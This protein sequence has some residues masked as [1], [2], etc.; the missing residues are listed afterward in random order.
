MRAL[1][2]DPGTK[3]FDICCIEDDAV[4]VVLDESI[5]TDIVAEDPTYVLETIKSVKPDVILG[6]SGYG[7]EFKHITQFREE[8]V[9]LTTLD[10][11]GDVEIPVLLGLRKL[12]WMM[13]EAGLNAYSIPGAILLPTIP[14]HRKLNKIDMGTADKTCVA[15]MAV[16][17]Q[18]EEYGLRYNETSLICVEMGFGYNAAIAVENGQIIDGIG[19]TIFPALSYLSS[20]QIDGEVAYLLGE[21]SKMDLFQ[22][23]ATF[24]A[25]GKILEVKDFFAKVGEKSYQLAWEG[26]VEGII[27]AVAML[28]TAFSK[29]PKEIILT[30]RLS[31]V[32]VV[33]RRL[34]KV[35]SEKFGIVPRRAKHMFA[36]RAKEAAQGA[37]LLANGIFGG[38]YAGLAEAMKI[39]EA[40]GTVI[41]YIYF[42]KFD[43]KRVLEKLRSA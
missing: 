25:A 24:I 38:K 15:A 13:K 23:G 17:D 18:A 43:K 1:G 19:G 33:Q 3:S 9:S 37:A 5:S 16:W 6:P 40:K 41:D 28:L 29:Q 27:K 4:N 8:D 2:I 20:G 39:K 36:E 21:L 7:L 32:N 22:A 30:G 26:M 35:L 12:L 42:M 31:R 34:E 14:L 11:D 10:K